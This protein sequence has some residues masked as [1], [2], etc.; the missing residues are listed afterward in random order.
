MNSFD[1]FVESAPDS[2]AWAYM[3]LPLGDLSCVARMCYTD[4]GRYAAFAADILKRTLLMPTVSDIEEVFCDG[5][6]VGD[7]EVSFKVRYKIPKPGVFQPFNA[8]EESAI[9]RYATIRIRR[10]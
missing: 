5:L 10:R 3:P 8:F 9:H 2:V 1:V 7:D 6:T 4:S